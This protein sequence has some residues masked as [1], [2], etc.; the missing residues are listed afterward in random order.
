MKMSGYKPYYF[1]E[2]YEYKVY[3]NVGWDY[4]KS[5]LLNRKDIRQR[6]YK[7]CNTYSEWKRHILDFMQGVTNHDDFL[8]LLI[9]RK[10]FLSSKLEALKIITIPLYV[11]AFSTMS[12]VSDGKHI[13][14]TV[15]FISAI[16]IAYLYCSIFRKNEKIN[17]YNDVIEIAKAEAPPKS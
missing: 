16:I 1:D 14:G 17:F 5:K 7:V 15:L 3:K 13:F 11:G 6:K 9:S 2:R 8:H 12:Y 4:K 10:N